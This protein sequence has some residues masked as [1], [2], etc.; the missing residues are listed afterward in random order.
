ML[1]VVI[2]LVLLA[3]GIGH[4]MGPLGMFKVATI[5]PAWHGDSWLL[6]G[7]AGTTVTNVVGM[8][9]WGV[10]LIGF[11]LVAAVVVGWLPEAW[12][13]PLAIVSAV[14]SIVGILLFPAAFPVF[15]TF[16]ALVVDVAVLVAVLWMHWVPSDLTA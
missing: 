8:T 4:S 5:N 14:A 6:T 15:S 3:H 2:A 1:K 13:Q 11:A 9:L 7:P 12:W 10:A 16:G